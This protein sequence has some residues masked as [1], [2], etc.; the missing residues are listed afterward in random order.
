M[1]ARAGRRRLLTSD[2]DYHLP[3]HLIAQTPAQPRD[4]SRLLVLHRD[5]GR[6]EH[7]SFRDLPHYLAEGDVLVLNDSRVFPA[8]LYGHREGTGGRVELLLLARLGDGVWRAMGRPGRA[9]R[10]GARVRIEGTQETPITV[11]V[12][13]AE[14]GG[15]RTVRLSSEKT[16]TPTSMEVPHAW[17]TWANKLMMFPNLMGWMKSKLSREAVTMPVRQWRREA[18]AA[19]LS[20]SSMTRPPNTLP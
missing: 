12:L 13:E 7:R 10:P 2:Y 1:D 20:I 6:I 5:A 15:L 3:S 14:E 8:R 11:E 18:I 17:L 9:L 19:A 4:S 16:L